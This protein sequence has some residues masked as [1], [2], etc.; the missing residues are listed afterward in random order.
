MEI[1]TPGTV[2][3][4]TRAGGR[5][6]RRTSGTWDFR[7]GKP[8]GRRTPSATCWRRCGL[9][10]AFASGHEA[11][12]QW[13]LERGLIDRALAH[14]ESAVS[15]DP[16]DRGVVIT[17]AT[18]LMAGGREREAWDLVRPLLKGA[19]ATVAGTGG[20]ASTIS[21]AHLSILYAR[22]VPRLRGGEGVSEGR[23]EAPPTVPPR[24]PP[25]RSGRVGRGPANFSRRCRSWSGR[26]GRRTCRRA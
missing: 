10:P 13:Y 5:S 24:I 2:R 14:S 11:L 20:G 1:S 19:A 12:A 15:A 9:D 16:W 3:L 6:S 17:R 22:M 18:V 23:S 21:V 26:R 25:G 4:E 8:T 7:P